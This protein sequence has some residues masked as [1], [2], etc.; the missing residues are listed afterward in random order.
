M[1]E[2]RS[3]VARQ[4]TG[5]HT[6]HE[7]HQSLRFAAGFLSF[8]AIP[9]TRFL[10]LH[11]TIRRSDS[12][13]KNPS[14]PLTNSAALA[15]GALILFCFAADVL[16]L[17]AW[18]LDPFSYISPRLKLFVA[19]LALLILLPA[20]RAR[21]I[22]ILSGA[23]HKFDPW[24][25][26]KHSVRFA[27]ILGGAGLIAFNSLPTAT[28]LLGD[29]A[30]YIR[31]LNADTWDTQQRM[32]RAPLAFLIVR[33]IHEWSSS[34]ETTYRIL[35]SASGFVFLLLAVAAARTA[36]DSSSRQWAV[37]AFL[38]TQGYVLLFFGYAENY[39]LVLAASMA[40]LLLGLLVILHKL[41][42]WIPSLVL[43]LA[44]PLHF[45]LAA[46]LPALSVLSMAVVSGATSSDKPVIRGFSAAS[47]PLLAM[48]TAVAILLA[49]GFDVAGIPCRNLTLPRY[50]LLCPL[51]A[52]M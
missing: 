42:V 10:S 13:M 12:I 46:F 35:S 26:P 41:P 37:L 39:G 28:H 23:A 50:S 22:A 20:S 15:S 36:A 19:V 17:P 45:S 3:I 33:A 2:T 40:F 29:G 48:A 8:C 14:R 30:L 31:E 49:I 5:A 34:G 27:L 21:L 4:E 16:H 24:I 25:V 32:G 44:I 51:R 11:Y 1:D 52:T 7:R 9:C 6:L 38:V 43:G 47:A 18:G